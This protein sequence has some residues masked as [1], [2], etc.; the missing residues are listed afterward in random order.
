MVELVR[1][2]EAIK[3]RERQ[4]ER[5]GRVSFDLDFEYVCVCEVRERVNDRHTHTHTS[6]HLGGA[7][8]VRLTSHPPHRD[9][10]AQPFFSFD[11][12][13]SIFVH[14]FFFLHFIALSRA[15]TIP[16]MLYISSIREKTERTKNYQRF[17]PDCE[18]RISLK[19]TSKKNIKEKHILLL[20]RNPKSATGRK[21]KSHCQKKLKLPQFRY[22]VS[23]LKR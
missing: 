16:Y 20:Q 8:A 15:L 14:F 5:E 10:D 17:E 3:L 1:P 21:K 22:T 2:L 11:E 4:G 12:T 6:T 18:E 19:T 9:H 23:E 13:P 7:C